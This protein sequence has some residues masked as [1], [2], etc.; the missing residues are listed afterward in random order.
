MAEALAPYGLEVTSGTPAELAGAVRS[1]SA[2][3]V[4][5]VK[6]VGFTPES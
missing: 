6:R 1:E 2:A 3:W 4:P 5:I